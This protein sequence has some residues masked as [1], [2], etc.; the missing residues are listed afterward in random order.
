MGRYDDE[1]VVEC[2]SCSGPAKI[3]DAT[4]FRC[5][6]CALHHTRGH[7]R[8]FGQAGI[9][10][11]KSADLSDWFGETILV[12]NEASVCF[13]CGGSI[14]LRFKTSSPGKIRHQVDENVIGTCS[15]CRAKADISARWV[16][17]HRR[18]GTREPY[19]GTNLFLREDTSKGTVWAYNLQHLQLLAEQLVSKSGKRQKDAEAQAMLDNLPQWIKSAKNRKVVAGA[20]SRIA[21][22]ID[23]PGRSG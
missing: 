4:R 13:K 2:P 15:G 21:S 20:L 14:D 11:E 10:F 6:G 22:T 18:G 23:Q 9:C 8:K 3:T 16:P 12:P 5:E 7:A 1:I 19:F 17:F